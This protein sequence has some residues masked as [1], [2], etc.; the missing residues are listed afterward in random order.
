MDIQFKEMRALLSKSED[1]PQRVPPEASQPETTHEK[2][3]MFNHKYSHLSRET[4]WW[5]ERGQK[6]KKGRLDLEWGAQANMGNME[7]K[8]IFMQTSKKVTARSPFKG[9]TVSEHDTLVDAGDHTDFETTPIKTVT[10]KASL[11]MGLVLAI[12]GIL[13]LGATGI[14]FFVGFRL[15]Q[16]YAKK[17]AVKQGLQ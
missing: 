10:N 4:G 8:R 9:T 12:G 2:V 3:Q 15:G 7:R 13:V 11:M 14:V 6:C 5:Y 17:A 16:W 1:S